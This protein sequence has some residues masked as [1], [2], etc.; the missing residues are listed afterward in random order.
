MGKGRPTK[1]S[2]IV[3]KF[4]ASEEA[5]EK[6][7]LVLDTL[8]GKTSVQ[9]AAEKLGVSEARFHQIRDEL[10]SGMLEAAE[11]KPVGRP[12]KEPPV[13]SE[14]EDLK[15]QL[16]QSKMETR[17]ARLRELLALSHPELVKRESDRQKKKR[18]SR[19]ITGPGS[20][21]SG[22]MSIS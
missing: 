7:R 22:R 17:I 19:I 12:R 10:L 11:P 14:V 3:T 16:A 9:E 20:P 2:E 4:E 18:P 8:S 13:P 21:D 1:G 5:R 15:E 6:A